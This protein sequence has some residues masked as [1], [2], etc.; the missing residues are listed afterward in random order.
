MKNI[1][2]LI[3][4][5]LTLVA[6]GGGGQQSVDDLIADGNLEQ[7][8]AKRSEVKAQQDELQAQLNMIDEA[9]RELDKSENLALV[10]TAT[11]NDTLFRHFIEVQGN[12]TTKQ[13]VIIYPEYQGTLIRV[14]VK[15]GDAVR[16][17]QLLAQI[18]DGG[19]GSQ[20][21]QLQ[22][23]EE[24]ARTTYERQKRLWD[25]QIGSE[26]QY[27]QAKTNYEAAKNAVDQLESQ[28]GKTQIT[29][30]FSGTIDDV[31]TDQGTVVSPGQALFRI[32][33]LDDM[34]IEAEVPERYLKTVTPGKDVAINLPI[35]G[36]TISSQVRQ[37][38][39]YIKP[40]NRSFS[41]EVD[42][43]NNTGNIKPNLTAR[44]R[45]NDYTNPKALLIPLSVIS[46]NAL[47]EQYVYVVMNDTTNNGAGVMA[48][49]KI[50]T[51]GLTQGDY[52]EVT[53]G[54]STGESIIV[55]GARTVKDG[56]NVQILNQ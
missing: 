39:N 18:D 14:L 36:E 49:R 25:Q 34:Y 48:K 21:G 29:A 11:I 8:R 3:A 37:T 22:V 12:V 41:I 7:I 23:Q 35:L 33:N 2:A 17:G 40:S 44:L 4:V 56:Q 42:V 30:P 9:I 50:I 1:I 53:S 13:N 31:I 51:T 38:G 26:I 45:I 43:P 47:G 5:I 32:V 6:C 20:L 46:E 24:L 10:T 15:E 55:E 52:T 28:L 16:K 54:I 27:L 19:L